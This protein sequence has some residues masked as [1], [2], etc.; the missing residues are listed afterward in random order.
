VAVGVENDHRPISN[1][2]DRIRGTVQLVVE[3]RMRRGNRQRQD[4]VERRD[5]GLVTNWFLR[6]SLPVRF[7]LNNCQH[8]HRHRKYP[9]LRIGEKQ[10]D[11]YLVKFGHQ[12]P[13]IAQPNYRDVT[14]SSFSK[15]VQEDVY[16]PRN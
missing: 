14:R 10:W 9:Y 8:I 12:L 16:C 11:A 13:S 15:I 1:D 4:F 3:V 2:P 7:Y 5:K 6:H